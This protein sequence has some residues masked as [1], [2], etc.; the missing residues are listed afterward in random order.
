[1][2]GRRGRA[3]DHLAGA[4]WI[5]LRS[6]GPGAITWRHMR[7]SSPTR[8]DLPV[9]AR[10]LGWVLVSLGSLGL[11]HCADPS[12]PPPPPPLEE[13]QPDTPIDP[14]RPPPPPRDGGT[15]DDG[16]QPPPPPPPP[17]PD[18]GE[19]DGGE[20]DGGTIGAGPWPT[21]AVKNY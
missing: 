20:P 10:S 11:L 1:M 19:P 5:S 15:T 9:R 18:G 3:I 6:I 14:S 7:C 13:G 21:D 8:G 12:R 17:P 4:N 2:P 16:G